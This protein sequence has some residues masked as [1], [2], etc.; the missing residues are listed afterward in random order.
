MPLASHIHRC[1]RTSS[2]RRRTPATII[3]SSQANA[4]RSAKSPAA[5]DIAGNNPRAYHRSTR[6]EGKTPI[7]ENM[8][9]SR[10]RRGKSQARRLA[11]E[12]VKLCKIPLLVLTVRLTVCYDAHLKNCSIDSHQV[13]LLQTIKRAHKDF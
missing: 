10:P 9:V 1:L 11:C 5:C 2:I 4:T 6:E 12:T 7:Q 3:G 8:K 13:L